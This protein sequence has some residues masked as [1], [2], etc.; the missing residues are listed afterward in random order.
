MKYIPTAICFAA[1]AMI[2]L[3]GYDGWGWFLFVGVIIL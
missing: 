1:A 3:K 2:A